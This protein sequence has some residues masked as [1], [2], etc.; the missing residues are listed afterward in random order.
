MYANI[1]TRTYTAHACTRTQKN[2]HNTPTDTRIRARTYQR[3]HGHIKHTHA[4][5]MSEKLRDRGPDPYCEKMSLLLEPLLMSTM[6]DTSSHTGCTS[7]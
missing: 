7:L 1:I 4:A 5:K 3:T 6:I 2:A